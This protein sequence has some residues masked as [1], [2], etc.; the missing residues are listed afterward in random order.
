MKQ[1]PFEGSFILKGYV[2]RL[3]RWAVD[4]LTL[5]LIRKRLS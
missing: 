3:V 4:L 1:M 2:L 5:T